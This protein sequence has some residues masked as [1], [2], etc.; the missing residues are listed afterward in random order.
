M[1]GPCAAGKEEIPGL[2][3]IE[4]AGAVVGSDDSQPESPALDERPRVV[5]S[6]VDDVLKQE[7]HQLLFELLGISLCSR[8]FGR[9]GVRKRLGKEPASGSRK[10]PRITAALLLIGQS[11]PQRLGLLARLSR[12]RRTR[13]IGKGF[14]RCQGHYASARRRRG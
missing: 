3:A 6:L 4:E 11:A 13:C 5:E 1:K 9:P 14:G 10:R 2:V 7:V 12:S 8:N